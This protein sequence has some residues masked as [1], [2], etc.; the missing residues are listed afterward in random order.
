MNEEN[1]NNDTITGTELDQTSGE[2][3]TK[4]T[5]FFLNVRKKYRGE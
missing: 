5:I 1:D 2:K 4:V 3:N